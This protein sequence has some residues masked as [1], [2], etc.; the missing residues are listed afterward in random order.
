[1]FKKNRE[2][3][4]IVLA[5]LGLLTFFSIDVAINENTQNKILKF[6]HERH[7]IIGGVL[8]AAAVYL[9][10]GTNTVK[11]KKMTGGS[12]CGSMSSG[13]SSSLAS[14]DLGSLDSAGSGISLPSSIHG[15]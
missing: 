5:L 9:F 2:L 8:L 15:T 12:G 6:I 11:S 7:Q 13:L 14:F 10:F 1:M 4:A 3:I